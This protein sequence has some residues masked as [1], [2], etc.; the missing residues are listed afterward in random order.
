MP[1]TSDQAN[2]YTQNGILDVLYKI[3][4]SRKGEHARAYTHCRHIST[5]EKLHTIF[6]IFTSLACR[7]I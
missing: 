2:G 6:P 5:P 4:P 7:L 1:L 3:L